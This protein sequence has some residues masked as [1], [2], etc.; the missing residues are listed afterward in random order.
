MEKNSRNDQNILEEKRKEYS[1]N[2]SL[3]KREKT[4]PYDNYLSFENDNN[5]GDF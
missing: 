3:G 2:S 1:L 5:E 4:L